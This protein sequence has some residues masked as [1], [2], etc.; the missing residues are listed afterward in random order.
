MQIMQNIFI[1][2]PHTKAAQLK[3]FCRYF[4]TQSLSKHNQIWCIQQCIY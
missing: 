3:H 4:R 2:A 1:N